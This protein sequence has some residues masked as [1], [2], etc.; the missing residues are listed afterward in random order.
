MPFG[1]VDI[2]PES[3]WVLLRRILRHQAVLMVIDVGHKFDL[4]FKL[5]NFLIIKEVAR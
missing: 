3:V 2:E 4:G 5:K 1:N